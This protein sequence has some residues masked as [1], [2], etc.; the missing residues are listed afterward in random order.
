[1]DNQQKDPES[2]KSLAMYNVFPS[3]PTSF[4]VACNTEVEVGASH[5]NI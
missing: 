4:I 3:F 2:I 5:T 1:M